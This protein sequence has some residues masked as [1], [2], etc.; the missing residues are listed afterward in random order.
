MGAL[1][2]PSIT[3]RSA[4][5][6]GSCSI[7]RSPPIPARDKHFGGLI[8]QRDETVNNT[9]KSVITRSIPGPDGLIATRHGP[10]SNDPWTFAFGER[11]GNRFFTDQTGAFVQDVGYQPYGEVASASGAQPG[12]QKY[13]NA[14][15]NGGDAL[16]ALGLSQLGAR[17]YDPVIGR[18]LSRD[19]LLIPRTAATTNPYAFA[20]ND[21]V[22]APPIL[23]G[24]CPECEE[25]PPIDWF[26][27]GGGGPSHPNPKPQ[28]P[29][30]SLPPV[31]RSALKLTK[32][33]GA[34]P[35]VALPR[36]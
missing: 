5:C 11:R 8:Y 36:A 10:R 7:A 27:S 3:T 17:I 33:E 35:E 34:R 23:H 18:F 15:W 19:P 6:S 25:L 30:T 29:H 1:T 2:Q 14:Q 16:A 32:Y 9:K 12:S 4:L 31:G 20:S 26:P 24:L 13:T 22:T 28:G 21:P